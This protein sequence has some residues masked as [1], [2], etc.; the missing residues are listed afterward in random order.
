MGEIPIYYYNKYE[1]FKSRQLDSQIIKD[2]IVFK[3]LPTSLK[4][5]KIKN[6]AY[7]YLLF[8]MKQEEDDVE[9]IVGICGVYVHIWNC[10]GV[11]IIKDYNVREDFEMILM[12]K[13]NMAKAS[14]PIMVQA[15]KP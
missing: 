5:K 13:L 1:R 9:W 15:S 14:S 11:V 8:H 12:F 10:D 4:K 3:F 6:T 2:L 7:A